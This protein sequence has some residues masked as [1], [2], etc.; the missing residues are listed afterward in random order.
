MPFARRRRVMKTALLISIAAVFTV[1]CGRS[2]QT[3]TVTSANATDAGSPRAN[4]SPVPASVRS[5]TTV[6]LV[7]CLQGPRPGVT[8]TSGT[9]ASE[10]RTHGADGGPFVLTNAAVESGSVDGNAAG[11]S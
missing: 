2:D 4:T 10:R 8:G 9:A 5:D 7:G 11:G 6:T 1:A 3:H